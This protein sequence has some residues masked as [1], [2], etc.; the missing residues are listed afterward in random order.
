MHIEILTSPNAMEAVRAEWKALFD[1]AASQSFYCEPDYCLEWISHYGDFAPVCAR[2]KTG[3]RSYLL[4]GRDEPGGRLDLAL[5]F[6]I[7]P[8]ARTL[9][10]L[11]LWSLEGLINDHSDESALLVRRGCEDAACAA[12]SRL[13]RRARWHRLALGAAE[14]GSATANIFKHLPP[15]LSWGYRHQGRDQLWLSLDGCFDTF[16]SARPRLRKQIDRA[17][18]RLERDFGP[19]E[20]ECI[21]GDRA[22]TE[23]FPIFVDV[24]SRSWK[25]HVEGGEALAHSPR[26]RAFFEGLTRRFGAQARAHVW[27]MRLGGV[28]AAA[29]LTYESHRRLYSFK[30]SFDRQFGA[31]GGQRPGFVLHALILERGW[32]HFETY[33]FMSTWFH[34]E[35]DCRRYG[36]E[37]AEFVSLDPARLF[38]AVGGPVLPEAA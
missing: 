6:R 4:L 2:A 25:A 31:R 22:A 1:D 26:S 14:V 24:D 23:G 3:A 19:I 36:T 21:T 13:T 20:L 16:L 28:P 17:R 12:V 7:V 29:E 37:S 18:R 32:E 34:E 38:S 15:P 30:T 27:V 33:D 9:P 8:A 5:P 10:G 35:W 11:T